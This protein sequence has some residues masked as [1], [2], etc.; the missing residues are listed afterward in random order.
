[1]IQVTDESVVHGFEGVL[2]DGWCCPGTCTHVWNYAQTPAFLYPQLERKMREIEFLHDTHSNGF[3]AH[4]SV[5]PLGE[6]WFDGPAAADGQMGSIM[7]VYREWK[8]SGD[9]QWLAG[10]WP[11]VKSA[12]EFAWTGPGIVENPALKYQE[13]Q[14]PWDPQKTGWMSGRQ[15]NTY[16]ISFFG[17]NSMT[18]S[19][20]LGALKAAHEMALALGDDNSAREYRKVYKS[21]VNKMEDLLWNGEYFIQLIE[22]EENIDR[23]DDYELSPE[24]D[25]GQV[26]PKYQYGDGCLS[27]QLLGQYLGFVS[28][29]GYFLDEEKVQS[30]IHS[31]YNYNY[32]E[33]LRHFA[34]VQRVYALNDESGVLLCS[35]PRGNRPVI[36]FVYSDEI[37]TGVEYQV[38]ASLIYSGFVEEGLKVVE[39]TQ[40]RYDGYK[41]NPFEHNESGVHYA[42]ALSSWSLL[43]ALSGY[44]YDGIEKRLSFSPQIHKTDFYTFWSTGSAW[45]YLSISKDNAILKVEHGEL[46]L[47]SFVVSDIEERYPKA[48]VLKEGDILELG[49]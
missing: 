13:R 39:S 21:G 37:W 14:S 35:W 4:R 46:E 22:R 49:L 24:N 36:P 43:L 26:I 33:S 1:M 15:H 25:V 40:A 17:P 32:C 3:Q 34:N 12:L 48:I 27:D 19:L 11:K 23:N 31:I 2:D 8:L 9:T 5:I 29:L 16:D 18:S 20:Y 30:A 45:G 6:Y 7:R 42:R 47:M 38:A 28:G 41:R 10:I 44:H